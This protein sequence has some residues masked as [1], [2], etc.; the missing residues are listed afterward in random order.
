MKAANGKVT[1][2]NTSGGSVKIKTYN[3]NDIL[4]WVPYQTLTVAPDDVARLQ[5]RGE[6]FIN[7]Y[8]NGVLFKPRLGKS[9][10]Y[11]GINLIKQL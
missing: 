11:S 4:H 3:E 8:V 10:I 6:K 1:F 5:A 7:V 9:Y 2:L